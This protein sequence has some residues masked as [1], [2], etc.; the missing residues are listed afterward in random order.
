VEKTNARTPGVL[1]DDPPQ[2]LEGLQ[3]VNGLEL[4]LTGTVRRGWT[5]FAA[6]TL[7]DSRIAE[8]N[9]PAEVGKRFINTPKHSFS[10]WT[11][12]LVRRFEFGGGARFVGLRYGNNTNTRFVEGYRVV[13]AMASYRLTETV[14]LRLNVYNLTDTY[15][16]ER[17]TGG[18]VVPGPGRSAVVSTSF[19]F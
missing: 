14:V 11:T 8:S 15:Y 19:R 2:V 13:D 3:R 12:Y 16:F 17:L 6:Y 7:L 5:L 1:P 9:N 18:H 4:G 10:L